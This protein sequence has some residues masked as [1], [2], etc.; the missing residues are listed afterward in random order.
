M[1]YHNDRNRWIKIVFQ[2]NKF[3]NLPGFSWVRDNKQ[4]IVFLQYAKVSVL[5]LARMQKNSGSSCWAECCGYV[6]RDLASFAHSRGDKFSLFKVNF[7]V[8]NIYRFLITV[9]YWDV[10]YSVGF[11]FKNSFYLFV[12]WLP[13]FWL[14]KSIKILYY[15]SF[16]S[17]N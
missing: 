4:N 12:H 8:N 11:S 15:L 5:S 3:N 6:V 1:W 16:Y 13:C 14:A 17:K 7:F 10:S 9:A 2:T